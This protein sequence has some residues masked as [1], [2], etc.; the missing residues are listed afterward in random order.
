MQRSLDFALEKNKNSVQKASKLAKYNGRS[1]C[2]ST[3]K[4]Q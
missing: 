2:S 3:G 4:K 1:R